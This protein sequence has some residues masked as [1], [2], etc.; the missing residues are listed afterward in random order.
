AAQNLKADI[1]LLPASNDLQLRPGP[2][3]AFSQLLKP[4]GKNVKIE[5]IDGIWGHLDGLFSILSNAP[6]IAE[7]LAE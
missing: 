5:D 2:V 6:V 7:F 1:L 4:Q 3:R